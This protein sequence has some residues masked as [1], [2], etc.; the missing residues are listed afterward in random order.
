MPNSA[1]ILLVDDDYDM[2]ESLRLFL[3]VRGLQVECAY[4]GEA[5]LD[6]VRNSVPDLCL[7][8]LVLPD[9]DGFNLVERIRELPGC[10]A[11]PVILMTAM[12]TVSEARSYSGMGSQRVDAFVVK[13]V[14]FDELN[15]LLD[16]LLPVSRL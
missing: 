4:T 7:L 11:I 14:D 8:D 12:G 15:A 1:R 9:T 5:A 13:P 2:V 6:C 16:A 10:A 3:E